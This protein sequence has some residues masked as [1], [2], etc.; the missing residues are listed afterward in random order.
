MNETVIRA[1]TLHQVA[2]EY[3]KVFHLLKSS[4]MQGSCLKQM[5]VMENEA[6]V[7]ADSWMGKCSG[8]GKKEAMAAMI[9]L[10]WDWNNTKA[11]LNL[12]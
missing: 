8:F 9:S 10:N 2:M 5:M 6:K 4:K 7:A 3:P 1:I 12:I 11:G